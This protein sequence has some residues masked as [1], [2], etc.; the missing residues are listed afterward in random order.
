MQSLRVDADEHIFWIVCRAEIDAQKD[1]WLPISLA[2]VSNLKYV[3][4]LFLSS[5]APNDNIV[6]DGLDPTIPVLMNNM[7][8]SLDIEDDTPVRSL[9]PDG[10]FSF[11]LTLDSIRH[12][13]PCSFLSKKIWSKWLPLKIS[14]FLWKMLHNVLRTDLK[15]RK[16]GIL[17]PSRCYCCEELPNHESSTYFLLCSKVAVKVWAYFVKIMG[18]SYNFITLPHILTHR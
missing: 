5:R 7:N 12:K 3:H 14:I 8:I 6:S 17:M 1:R 15:V 4:E 16:K 18:M 10:N 9:S 13:G 11:S 2:H